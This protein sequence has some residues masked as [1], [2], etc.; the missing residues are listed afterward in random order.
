MKVIYILAVAEAGPVTSEQLEEI[1]EADELEVAPLE[2]GRGFTVTSDGQVVEIRHERTAGELHLPPK[3]VT[4]TEAA[5]QA[6]REARSVYRLAVQPGGEQPS[7]AVFEALWCARALM[8]VVTGVLLDVSAFKL[9]EPADV[10]EITELEFDIRDHVTLHAVEAAEGDLWIHSH[11]MD[12]FAARA[13]EAFHL[14]HEDL[15][16]VETFFH[17]LCTDLAFGQG[18]GAGAVVETGEGDGFMLQPSE[19]A[20]AKLLG[21]GMD[22]FEGHEG[23]YFTIVSADGRHTVSE[24]LAPYRGRFDEEEP[25]LTE[26][27]QSHAQQNLQAFKGRFLRKG[28]MEP[29]QF[30]VRVRFETHPDPEGEPVQEDLWAEVLAW[31]EGS[32]VA[33]LV[34][35]S[36]QTTEWRKG[37]QV[38]L[39]E[40]RVNALAVAREGRT[41]DVQELEALLGAERPS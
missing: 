30:L 28:L 25:E 15:P 26:R 36:S 29:T 6:L 1:I 16:A 23:A 17:Q 21:L 18:P 22:F 4:G 8:S 19:S 2:D 31:E 27:L 37:V 33:R 34:D 24:V 20:R 3:L 39:E 13:L 10:A 38:E 35:G 5:K 7:V 12:K 11:G 14:S 32:L 41:L 9:H 40:S